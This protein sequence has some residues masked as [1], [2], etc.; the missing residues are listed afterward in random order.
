MKLLFDENLSPKLPSCL[1][2]QEVIQLL[3]KTINCR[4]KSDRTPERSS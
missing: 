3:L 4:S 1:E 2:D